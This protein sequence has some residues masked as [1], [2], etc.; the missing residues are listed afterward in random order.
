MTYLDLNPVIIAIRARPDE[1]EVSG[2]NLHH[3]V[4]RHS[5]AFE[6]DGRVQV[7]ANCNCITL[8][9]RPEQRSVFRAAYEEW[10][11]SYWRAIEINREF[12][13]HF[14]APGRWRR[15]CVHV[16]TRLLGSLQVSAPRS[17]LAHQPI[18]SMAEKQI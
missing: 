6:K 15:L 1:F 12:A 11:A 18:P 8:S 2:G 7:F 9:T 16:L 5:F 17:P 13:T 10:H 3:S 14:P 4:S